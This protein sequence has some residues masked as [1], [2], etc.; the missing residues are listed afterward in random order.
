MKEVYSLTGMPVTKDNDQIW[1][2]EE[3]K[4][5]GICRE[6]HAL[7][8]EGNDVLLLAHFDQLLHQLE[9]ALRSASTSFHAYSGFDD[10]VL[11]RPGAQAVWVGQARNFHPRSMT[12]QRDTIGRELSMIVAEH[13]PLPLR[14][15]AIIDAAEALP[16]DVHICFHAA[17]TDALLVHFGVE[18]IQRLYKQLGVDEESSLSNHLIDTAIRTAQDKIAQRVFT[19]MPTSSAEDWFK[20]NLR[21]RM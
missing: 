9:E 18:P 21:E 14:D 3:H 16:R 19:E 6:I 10:S 12:A 20:Y 2:D 7:T 1:V 17:L 13:H 5:R 8:A 11:L 4:V 15:L